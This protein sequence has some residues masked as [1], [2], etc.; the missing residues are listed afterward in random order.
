MVVGVVTL[1]R[2]PQRG[3]TAVTMRS[4]NPFL[5]MAA[6]RLDRA[7]QADQRGDVVG[8]DIEDRAAARLEEERRVGMPVLHAVAHH[9]G[10]AADHACRSCP[11]REACRTVWAPPPRKVSGAPPSFRPRLSASATSLLASSRGERQRLLRIGVLAGREDLVAHLEMGVRHGEVD[12]RVDLVVLEEAVDRHGADRELLGPGLRDRRNDVGDGD[13]LD[14]GEQLAE[15]EIGLRD[16]A[17]ADDADFRAA[18]SAQPFFAAVRSFDDICRSAPR[19]PPVGRVVVLEHEQVG[20]R[21]G[22]RR[23]QR[24]PVDRARADIGP[25]V[26]LGHA[27]RA[28]CP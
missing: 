5:A 9:M 2:S 8:A 27:R 12:D 4:A 21:G 14:V 16:V 6:T 17:A 7:E 3:R 15:A 24:L 1:M 23:P 26:V 28:R 11:C 25:A 13:D 19:S 20:A 22:D 18:P 10:G